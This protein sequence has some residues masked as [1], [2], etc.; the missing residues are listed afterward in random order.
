MDGETAL[1]ASLPPSI[2]SKT[3]R[4]TRVVRSF[5]SIDAPDGDD[6]RDHADMLGLNPRS[7][8]RLI[9]AYDKLSAGVVPAASRRGIR[10]SLPQEAEDIVDAVRTEMGRETPERLMLIEIGRRCAA[11][12][13]RAPSLNALRTRDV[14]SEVDLRIRLRRR[15]D[16]VVDACPLDIDVID[17]SRSGNTEAVAWLTGILAGATGLCLGHMVTAGSPSAGDMD[18]LLDEAAPLGDEQRNVL[19]ATGTLPEL[20]ART[21]DHGHPTGPEFDEA[22]SRGLLAGAAL[23]PAFGLKIGTVSLKARRREP[24]GDKAVPIAVARRLVDHMLGA[25]RD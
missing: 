11:A 20:I 24:F 25:D 19:I 15:F 17:E 5:R 9:R 8:Y 7:F 16:I 3:L 23:V 4:R 13:I 21:S 2:W 22:T 1:L 12:G 18:E 6:I 10:R 14:G